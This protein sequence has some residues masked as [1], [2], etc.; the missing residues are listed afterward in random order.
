M[1]KIEIEDKVIFDK[2]KSPDIINSEYQFTTIFAWAHR[3]NFCYIENGEVLYIFGNQNN[4]NLQCYFPIGE[5]SIEDKLEFLKKIFR[6]N[7]SPINIR[8]LSKD[9][10]EQIKPFWGANFSIG[11]KESYRDYICDYNLLLEYKGSEY[12]K[13]RKLTKT[14]LSRYNYEYSSISKT[15][16]EYIKDALHSILYGTDCA[17]DIDEWTAYTRILENYENLGLRGGFIAIDGIIEAI[18]IAESCFDTIYIHVRR[19]NKKYVGIYPAML[20]LLMKNEFVDHKYKYVNLQDDMGIENLRKA[21][22]SYKPIMLFE[23]YFIQEEVD[24]YGNACD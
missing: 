3:Y 7:M 17:V 16:I 21:K 9:M 15:N 22:L 19:C 1:K 4:G 20:Q 2:Y 11:T 8:P 6:E 10:L 12:K 18:S 5:K 13:K 14:F 23:K 24:D